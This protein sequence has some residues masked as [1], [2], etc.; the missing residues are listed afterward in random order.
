MSNV[1]FVTSIGFWCGQ[2][3]PFG[4]K[5]DHIAGQDQSFLILGYSVAERF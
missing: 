3:V 4:S 1:D 5:K 2:V